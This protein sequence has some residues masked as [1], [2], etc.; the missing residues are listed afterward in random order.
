MQQAIRSREIKFPPT[1][2]YLEKSPQYKNRDI[3]RDI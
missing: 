1:Q 3:L 2:I